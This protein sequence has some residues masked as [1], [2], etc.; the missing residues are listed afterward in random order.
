M[1]VSPTLRRQIELEAYQS[2]CPC[3]YTTLCRTKQ[4]IVG[5]FWTIQGKGTVRLALCEEQFCGQVQTTTP[6][7]SV[8][9]S[10]QEEVFFTQSAYESQHWD[11]GVANF[12]YGKDYHYYNA[13]NIYLLREI[14]PCKSTIKDKNNK[15][16]H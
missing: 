16:P 9:Y 5:F 6:A 8:A 4:C 3:C 7:V 11:C 13:S 1:I 14:K 12:F 2:Y 10:L 15:R